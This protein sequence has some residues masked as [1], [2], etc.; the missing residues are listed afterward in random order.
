MYVLQPI[1]HQIAKYA[2]QILGTTVQECV[3]KH[4]CTRINLLSLILNLVSICQDLTVT[5]YVLN[6][7]RAVGPRC[8]YA[9]IAKDTPTVIG[10][11]NAL[12]F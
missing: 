3:L 7:K 9:I 10:V 4:M 2:T 12:P 8:R 1:F 11:A 6:G 5:F